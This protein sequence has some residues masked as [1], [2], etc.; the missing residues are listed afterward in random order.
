VHFTD[1]TGNTHN[2]SHS[3]HTCFSLTNVFLLR[4]VRYACASQVAVGVMLKSLTEG[5]GSH[6]M[7]VALVALVC[8]YV[9][10]FAWSW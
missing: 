10:G 7:A 4:P 5:A 3:I 2:P 1:G 8:I 9:A 6:A